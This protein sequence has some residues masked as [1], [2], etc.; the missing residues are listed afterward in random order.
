MSYLGE[1]GFAVRG[2]AALA[3][4]VL[5]SAVAWPAAAQDAPDSRDGRGSI[6]QMER[7]STHEGWVLTDA[8]LLFTRDGGASWSAMAS[9]QR[10]DGVTDAF[11]LD[12]S[13]ARLAGVDSDRLVVLDTA[14][15]GATWSEQQ[16]GASALASGQV[17]A[18][19]QI[20]F[21]D[22]AHGWLLGKV[23]TSAAFSVAELLRTT[24]GGETWERLPRP[25]AAGRFVF[26]D[27]Q[28]GF[29]TGAPVS[30]RLYRTLDGGRSWQEL[31]LAVSAPAGMALYGLPTFH[32]L[33]RGTLA[34]TLL[35]DSP[36]LLTFVTSDGGRRW[37]LE[38]TLALPAG[39]YDEPVPVA[40][41]AGGRA[42]ALAAQGS[43][44]FAPDTTPRAL[45][46][47]REDSAGPEPAGARAVSVRALSLTEDGSGWALVA[48]GGCEEGVCRQVTRLVAVDG[49]GEVVEAVDDLLVRTVEE[50]QPPLESELAASGAVISFDKGFDKC[51]AP[52][53][54][55]MQTWKTYGPYR[56]ANIYYGGAARGCAQ[57]NLNASWVSTVFKQGW[58]LIPT[59]VGP[60]APCTG[61]GTRFSYNTATARNQGLAEADAAVNAASALGLGAGTPLYYDLE[62]YSESSASCSAAVR[63]FV[64]AWTERVNARGYLAG[65]Y[66]NARNAQAD[67]RTG[68]IAN[69]PD[70]VWLV[71]WVCGKTAT[72]CNWSPT[73]FGIPGL[74]DAYWANNQRIR[75]YWGDH[76]E[77]YGGVK[78]TIDSDFANAPVAGA[79]TS[80]SCQ[81]TVPAGHWKGRYF[82]N[83]SLSG[84]PVMVRNDGTGSLNFDWGSGSPSGACGV[85]ANKFSVRW[86]R[87]AYF[88]A[89]M[90]QFSVTS[91]D[92]F[93]L[94]VD[95]VLQLNAWIDQGPT[96]YTKNVA[97]SAGNHTIKM[98]YYEN[99]GGAVAKLSWKVVSSLT[100]GEPK[101][102]F[103]AGAQTDV[104]TEPGIWR[105]AERFYGH[106]GIDRIAS[107]TDACGAAHIYA[108]GY[109]GG[110]LAEYL[111]KFGGDYDRLVLRGIADRP[112]PVNLAIYI[113]GQ[114]RTTVSWN[115][116]ND[117]NQDVAVKISGVSYGTHAIAV[118]FTNDY[119]DPNTKSDRNIYLDALVVKQS[120]PA[121]IPSVTGGE[122]KGA[123]GAGG[124]TD[125]VTAPG[126][127]RWSEWF[128]GH[129]GIDQIASRTDACGA[130]HVYAMGYHGGD[131]AE[132]L[133]K[134]GGDYDRLVLRGI[135]DRPGPVNLAIYIDGQYRTTVSW[136]NNNDCNQDVA[137]KITGI[138]YGTH[139]IA[140]KFTNDYY[141]PN[142]K[143]DRNI[144]LDGLKVTK[145]SAPPPP[146]PP[147]YALLAPVSAGQKLTVVHGYNDPLPGETCIIGKGPDHCA[148]QKYGL[149]LR[150]SDLSD[151]K[152]LAPL[153]GKVGWVGGGCL[154]LTTEDSLNL[155]V[156]HF[157]SFS[158]KVG[159]Q[160]ERGAVLGN[161]NT[162]WIHLS[163]D[164]R[165]RSASRPPVP[166]SGAHTFEGTSL[167]PL[168]DS[169]RNQYYGRSF[170]STNGGSSPP[171]PPPPTS[172]LVDDGDSGFILYGPTQYWHRESI[173]YGGDMY[174]TYVN[175]SV[176]SNKVRWKP[177]LSG[178][179]NYRV[180]VFV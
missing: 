170:T 23:A 84:S 115:N 180:Q 156:C 173:G 78:F 38:D 45:S 15:G 62:L 158:V 100:G 97:L 166:F 155:N 128:Y 162:S 92:G 26:V 89:G 5:A 93:R 52:T 108:M 119:Y 85:P 99:G 95:G 80:S 48:E 24:D 31:R 3:G 126:S 179:G 138:S 148:N 86:T 112:G 153:P 28:R 75:Q 109:H 91:D 113:D 104:V 120:A 7:L 157:G 27:A 22:G 105:F 57:V 59:W 71:P 72:S 98:E 177:Q 150:P 19:A 61:Y 17:Y 143:S 137:V 20:R 134:F 14:D 145:S 11:F 94:Y 18:R 136:N 151:L 25:P 163:L 107:R 87:T 79:D 16:V 36:R 154:G 44:T 139:A 64:N 32:S 49:S 141:D 55:Q 46:L 34:V 65:V 74:N 175:G 140:V 171:P 77:T 90:Y 76:S 2:L 68:V 41:S 29:M 149:D 131:L 114:Y 81:A 160:V 111:M 110:D 118:K 152:I 13:H 103:G 73:V 50:V 69:P 144:Y 172:N 83:V 42:L 1:R 123:F 60:Q 10:L 122:P 169:Q 161:R 21:L 58:R 39:D 135:A 37:R 53:T 146:P 129:Q 101:G 147:A 40:L 117:C 63:A 132:Y 9:G 121:P 12:A 125:E 35:G 124:Q 54:G 116:N 106:Q 164:D 159:Q 47:A 6:R 33:Y 51:A 4:I 133:M 67:W 168:A 127:W 96:T 82:N 178:S 88:N 167:P 174:W 70:A 43:V 130:P 8:A 56:D 66:G 165:Y 176:V 142:T 102:T 30:E